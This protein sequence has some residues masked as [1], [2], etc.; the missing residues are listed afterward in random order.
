VKSGT[1]LNREQHLG[2]LVTQSVDDLARFFSIPFTGQSS[3]VVTFFGMRQKTHDLYRTFDVA[4]AI[5]IGTSKD[6]TGANPRS[7]S[8]A[9]AAAAV[10][11]G[12]KAKNVLLVGGA[13]ADGIPDSVTEA[14]GMR[15][16]VK[17]FFWDKSHLYL[18]TS[19]TTTLQNARQA[20][21][22]MKQQGW[23]SAVICAEALHARR[24]EATFR[25]QWPSD[26]EIIVIP[27]FGGYGNSS[28]RFTTPF[29]FLLYNAAATVWSKLKGWT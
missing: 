23:T 10:Y 7:A 2:G 8:N 5:G 28:G 6:G 29:Q 20:L 18:E 12:K 4:I 21:G 22:I 3:L 15:E 9:L 25:K 24:V 27:T 16:T 11:I 14:E 26:Y 19:S 17:R 13:K 1:L